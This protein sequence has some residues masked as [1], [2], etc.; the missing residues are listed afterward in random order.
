MTTTPEVVSIEP[1]DRATL[2]TDRA[3]VLASCAELPDEIASPQEY[4]AVIDMEARLGTFLAR[5]EPIFADHTRLVYRAWK[6][7]L[8]VSEAFL[9][10]PQKLRAKCRELLT[11]WTMREERARRE[12]ERKIA[13]ARAKEEIARRAKEAKLLEQQGQKELAA[14]VK[15]QPIEPE[16]VVLPSARP[17]V[18]GVSYREDWYWEPIGGDTPANRQRVVAGFVKDALFT[19][20]VKL[21]DGGLTAFA[22]RTKGTVSVPGILIRSR[23]VMVRR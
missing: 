13:E 17:Q 16:P 9:G 18:D 1:P 14:Q 10:A 23:K 21:D 20:L 15:A 12:E 7:S 22:K 6:S 2:D 8:N 4:K 19:Q 5:A 11:T 3:L